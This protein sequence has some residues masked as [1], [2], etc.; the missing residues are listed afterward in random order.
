MVIM[1]KAGC[2]LLLPG[3]E[4]G[5]QTILNNIKKGTK[6][7]QFKPF[8]DHARRAGMQVHGCFIVGNKGET[9]ETMQETL[10]VALSLK[11]DT[12][13]FYPLMPFPGTEAYDWAVSKGYISG[14][15]TDYLKEDGNH[16]TSMHND[17]ISAKEFVK[18]CD[19][20]R[21]KFYLRPWY[22]GHRLVMGIK[23]PDDLKRALKSFSRFK[24]YL[25]N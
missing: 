16:N 12:I 1:K 2:R 25:L 17:E 15:Y 11:L 3:F 24:E 21:R 6:V 18:F 14:K 20:A 19:Y 5:S 22:I 8:V 7:K 4:S 23:S 13:Q 10:K 9:R